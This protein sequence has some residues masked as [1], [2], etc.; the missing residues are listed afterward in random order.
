MRPVV[1]RVDGF[2]FNGD[3]AGVFFLTFKG[4]H[5]EEGHSAAHGGSGV[6]EC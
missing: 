6:T 4:R 2:S 3:R 1:I 5:I